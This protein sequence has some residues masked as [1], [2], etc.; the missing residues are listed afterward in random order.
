MTGEL[1][2][3]QRLKRSLKF[4]CYS[5][6]LTVLNGEP[7]GLKGTGALYSQC[8]R[9]S[10]AGRI[11]LFQSGVQLHYSIGW[12]GPS[13]I[14]RRLPSA[15][16]PDKAKRCGEYAFALLPCLHRSR[17]ETFPVPHSFDIVHDWD[18]CVS[19]EDKVAVHAMDKEHGMPIGG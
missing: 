12:H 16:F 2:V 9:V 8:F 7:Y 11:L 1:S 4:F 10:V 18:C 5:S 15:A 6:V 3:L 13:M 19:G 14:D 17:D